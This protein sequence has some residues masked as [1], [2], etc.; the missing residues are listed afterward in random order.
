MA[1][2]LTV[3]RGSLLPLGLIARDVTGDVLWAL[4]IAWCMGAIAPRCPLVFRSAVALTVCVAVE[5]SQLVHTPSLDALRATTLGH[6]ALGQGFDPRDL[7]AYSAGV[8]LAALGEWIA[9]R[10]AKP[11]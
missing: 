9:V 4:M 8:A 2:G 7:A 5:L 3:H 1:A 11:H 6:L 10:L